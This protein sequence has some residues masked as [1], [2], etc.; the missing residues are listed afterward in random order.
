M[1]LD[2]VL[3]RFMQQ[4]PVTVMAHAI[5]DRV[6]EPGWLDQ[7][8]E[9]YRQRQY[10]RELLFSTA[11]EYMS[12]VALGLQRSLHAAVQASKDLPVSLAAL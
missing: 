11:V 4:S 3:S 10:K 8:F 12:V 5:F 7:L 6:L 9:T 1:S 2:A